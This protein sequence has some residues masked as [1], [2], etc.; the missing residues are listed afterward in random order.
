M[1][2]D[3]KALFTFITGY[4]RIRLDPTH[5]E[6]SLR[7]LV[8]TNPTEEHKNRNRLTTRLLHFLGETPKKRKAIEA[9]PPPKP[10]PINER[11]QSPAAFVQTSLSNPPAI[12]RGHKRQRSDATWYQPGD[13]G[14]LEGEP[15]SKRNV[16]PTQ[17]P[18]PSSSHEPRKHSVTSMLSS[19]PGSGSGTSSSHPEGRLL[20]RPGPSIEYY[21]DE[22]R[23]RDREGQATPPAE[24]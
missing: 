11:P 10:P 20:P 12:R 4:R 14:T 24:S 3:K 19:E 6:W 15:R 22:D 7:L 17:D 8:R 23:D 2:K 21:G 16:S 1:C 18:K 5:N 9:P 13:P